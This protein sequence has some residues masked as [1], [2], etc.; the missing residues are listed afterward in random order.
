IFDEVGHPFDLRLCIQ[1]FTA[2]HVL[3][4]R[5]TYEDLD[6]N[7]GPVDAEYTR[8][9]ELVIEKAGRM[10][11]L[12]LWLKMELAEGEDLDVLDD[13][14]A[15][16]PAYF[17]L[18]DPGI[19]VRPGDRLALE[20][21]GALPDGGVAP[22]YG[23]RGTLIRGGT[24]EAVPFEFVS[25]H[26]APAFRATPFYQ[27]LFPTG[28]VPVAEDTGG[29]LPAALKEHLRE[30]LPE[31]M[32]PAAVVVL[33]ALPLTPNGKVDRKALPAPE[34]EAADDAYVAPRNRV[35]TLLAEIW[36]EV[37]WLDRVGVN[38]SFF[39]LGGDSILCI[40]VVSKARRAG[41]DLSP[42]Q[43]FEYTTIAELAAVVGGGDEAEEAPAAADESRIEGRLPL[44]PIQAWFLEQESPTP[45]HY[46]QS[47]LLEIDPSLPDAA[48]ESA[49]AAVL[50]H[51]DALRLRVRRAGDGWEQWHAPEAGIALERVYLSGLPAEEQA[52]IEAETAAQRQASL[53]LEN[54]PMGR[55]VLFDRGRAGRR[56]LLVLHHLVVDTVSWSVLLD[57]LERAAAQVRDGKPIGLGAKGT[58]FQQWAE[59]LQAY[60]AGDALRAESAH[61]LAQGDDGVTPLPVDGSGGRTVA[62]ARTLRVRLEVDETEALLREMP[63]AYRTQ[64]NDALLA[65]LAEAVTG[66]V[67]GTRIRLALEG[68]GREEQVG[69]GIDLTRTVGWFTSLYPVVLDV[70]GCDGPGA[71]IKRVKEQFRAIPNRG[72]GYGVLRHLSPDAELR[73]ALAAHA[74]PEIAFNYLGQLGQGGTSAALLRWADGDRGPE[75]APGTPLRP[76]ISINAAV[77]DGALDAGFTFCEG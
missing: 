76:L 33:D 1:G 21:W 40:Q 32:V 8:R 24:G 35:E 70:A 50:A 39:E 67:G 62:D 57:D 63:A 17:P 59:T 71:R 55:A 6:F 42:P 54:G 47:A 11:G 72:I 45:W 16:L 52:R 48:L 58:S 43:M 36:A 2:D 7:A 66:W 34:Y 10:D 31:Y 26:S 27:R 22:D 5:A 25:F 46:N 18:F 74:E 20:C 64:I 23:V 60:A 37:L 29:A 77:V 75:W 44:T 15:W 19:E 51:H 49:L 9:E 41:I 4:T 13:D 69:D 38:E 14:T 28:E 68:H 61:W 65:A 56:L 3:S 30:R 12:L 73:G 53:H